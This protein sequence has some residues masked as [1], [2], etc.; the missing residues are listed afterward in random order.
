MNE[1]ASEWSSEESVCTFKEIA[2]QNQNTARQ[3]QQGRTYVASQVWRTFSLH[4]LMKGFGETRHQ[5]TRGRMAEEQVRTR[6][7]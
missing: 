5:C 6:C 2:T 3:P 4:A 7:S 1:I